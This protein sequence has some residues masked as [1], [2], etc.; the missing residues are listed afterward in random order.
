MNSIAELTKEIERLTHERD[1][2]GQAIADAALK[3]GMY[4]GEVSLTG[5]HLIMFAQHLG[6]A[7]QQHAQAALSDEQIDSIVRN[8]CHSDPQMVTGEYCLTID[9]VRAILATRQPSPERSQQGGGVVDAYRDALRKIRYCCAVPAALAMRKIAIDALDVHPPEDAAPG[10]AKPFHSYGMSAE[11][12]QALLS[13][14]LKPEEI[15]GADDVQHDRVHELVWW[16]AR[17]ADGNANAKWAIRHAF[18]LAYYVANN[19]INHQIDL[20]SIRNAAFKEGV[21]IT[22]AERRSLERI[23]FAVA[24][25]FP[26]PADAVPAQAGMQGDERGAFEEWAMPQSHWRVGDSYS[27]LHTA[28]AWEAWQARAEL[29]Q[30]AAIHLGNERDATITLTEIMRCRRVLR[31]GDRVD[32]KQALDDLA[33]AFDDADK[34]VVKHSDKI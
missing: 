19:G 34:L 10:D 29:A 28:C 9:E 31:D 3:A 20:K 11:Q 18:E 24:Q 15:G 30:R 27:N 6:E 21:N 25:P 8:A 26:A 33:K 17:L 32:Q 12:V 7:A 2:L 22:P 1:T 5:A 16:F 4:N 14:G 13:N 23:G